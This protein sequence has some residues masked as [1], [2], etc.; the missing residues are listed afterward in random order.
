MLL[1]DLTKKVGVKMSNKM[2]PGIS[3]DELESIWLTISYSIILA[4]KKMGI[5]CETSG[6]ASD[7][8]LEG[9]VNVKMELD[10]EYEFQRVVDTFSCVNKELSKEDKKLG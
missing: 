4:C 9:S 5:V 6:K 7:D 3:K 10:Q 8:G 2:K 1:Y